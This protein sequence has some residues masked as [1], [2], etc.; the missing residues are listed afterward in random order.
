MSQ[1]QNTIEEAW[2]DRALLA[3]KNVQ[4]AIRSVIDQ[5]DNGELRVAEPTVHGWQV[6]E[7][8]KKQSSCTF[9]FKAWKHCKQDHWNFMTKSH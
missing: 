7:W 8:V 4:E 2:E 6:N 5:L 3:D 9:P 1:F